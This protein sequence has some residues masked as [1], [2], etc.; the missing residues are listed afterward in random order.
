M[1]RVLRWRGV[2]LIYAALESGQE[3]SD[4][5]VAKLAGMEREL[6]EFAAKVVCGIA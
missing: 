3:V 4:A 2:L 5:E 6:V 1:P